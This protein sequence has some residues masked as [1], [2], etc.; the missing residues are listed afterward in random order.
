MCQ[1]EIEH[2]GR[3]REAVSCIEPVTEGMIVRTATEEVRDARL[4]VLEFM[5]LNHPVDCPSC[6]CAGECRLQDYFLDWGNVAEGSRRETPQLHKPKRQAVGPRVMLD[7][8][9]CVLCTR[10]VRFLEE[11]TGT[12]E[13]GVEERAALSTLHLAEGRELDNPYSG[14][15]VDLCPV[16]ALTDRDFRFTRRVWFLDRADSVCPGCSRGCNVEIQ[17]DLRHPHKSAEPS[18]RVLRLKPR[19][20]R[21]IN[22]WWL[23]DRGRYGYGGIDEGRL[24]RVLIRRD[25]QVTQTDWDDALDEAA[26]KLRSVSDR[27]P[28]QLAVLFSPQMTNESLLAARTLFVDGLEA[29]ACDYGL[30]GEIYG[31][32]DG[33]LRR[34]DLNPNRRACEL[35]KLHRGAFPHGELVERIAAGEIRALVSFRADLPELLGERFPEVLSGLKLLIVC[36]THERRWL[37]RP[38][39][40]LPVAVYA[41]QDGSFTNFEGRVQRIHRA[42]PPAGDARVELDLLLDLAG[43]VGLKLGFR[44]LEGAQ[45]LLAQ[46]LE[47]FGEIDGASRSPASRVAKEAAPR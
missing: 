33:F 3:S 42:F 1:V 29:G 19:Y 35:M 34:A 7:S 4:G 13:L 36:D 45:R 47:G 27:H 21:E 20:N 46:E 9:R 44:T 5:L 16:G 6:D 37:D 17:F 26:R 31:E 15:V 22:Q 10:C 30:T 39:I 32:E 14:N 25:G 38:D 41:E 43:R 11:V 24:T 28:E 12:A 8:E 23:C 2:N 18:R 40:L